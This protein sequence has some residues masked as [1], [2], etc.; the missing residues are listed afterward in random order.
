MC[1]YT[2]HADAGES[3]HVHRWRK[4]ADEDLKA[5][6]HG[7]CTARPPRLLIPQPQEPKPGRKVCWSKTLTI[8]VRARELCAGGGEAALPKHRRAPL[9]LP[10]RP[11]VAMWRELPL[12]A[13]RVLEQ[14]R[15]D[16]EV[17]LGRLLQGPETGR[18][19]SSQDRTCSAVS[20][21]ADYVRLLDGNCCPGKGHG[22][23]RV[24]RQYA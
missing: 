5:C 1:V 20:H 2:I 19:S 23:C 9:R 12:Q 21:G 16:D 13:R 24:A 7:T 22:Y 6:W 8:E 3:T 15:G 11:V 10:R 14:L 17:R 18:L 4:H